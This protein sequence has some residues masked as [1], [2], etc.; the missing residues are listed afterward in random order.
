MSGELVERQ[1]QLAELQEA[2]RAELSRRG[3]LDLGDGFADQADGGVAA[4]GEGDAFRPEVVGARPAVEVAELLELAEQ[5]VQRLFADPQSGGQV[6]RPCPFGA[7][8]L[9]DAQVGGVEIRKTAPGARY[10]AGEQVART[11]TTTTPTRS[12][13]S[14]AS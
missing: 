9:E 12:R 1:Q 8:V 11:S 13:S 5:V 2:F 3:G 6:G 10:A 14:R 7:G 4:G